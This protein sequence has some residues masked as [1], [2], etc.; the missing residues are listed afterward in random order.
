MLI[1]KAAFTID[2]EQRAAFV[3]ALNAFITQ[4]RA[5]PGN[6]TFGLYEAVDEANRFVVF[7]EFKD[8]AALDAH[9]AADYTLAFRQT[10]RPLLTRRE[11]T[12]VFSVARADLLSHR[13]R[14]QR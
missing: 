11:P 10:I 8:H 13:P 9:E 4:S 14:A 6:I 5:E 7:G 12:M 2:V 3:A 1:L